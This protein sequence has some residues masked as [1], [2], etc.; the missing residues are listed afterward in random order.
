MKHYL[1]VKYLKGKFETVSNSVSFM[2]NLYE[3]TTDIMSAV[4]ID[5][6]LLLTQVFVSEISEIVSSK[7]Y[8]LSIFFFNWFYYY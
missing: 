6:V 8:F 2:Q 7:I 5:V 4:E 1:A 3:V